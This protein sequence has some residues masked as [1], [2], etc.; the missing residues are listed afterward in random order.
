MKHI[1]SLNIQVGTRK[2]EALVDTGA[3]ISCISSKLVAELELRVNRSKQ[4][5]QIKTASGI[6]NIASK[7]VNVP[8][9][10]GET[11]HKIKFCIIKSLNPEILI[12]R[13]HCKKMKIDIKFSTNEL[14]ICGKILNHDEK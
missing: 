5:I 12:G 8:I 9:Q 4:R 1:C 2:M 10:I 7:W 3:N 14:Y 13:Q 11:I 6:S